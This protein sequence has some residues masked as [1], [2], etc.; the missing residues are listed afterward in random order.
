M[1]EVEIFIV[2]RTHTT[3]YQTEPN[4]RLSCVERLLSRFKLYTGYLETSQDDNIVVDFRIVVQG[5]QERQV[6]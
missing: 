4:I 2:G 5:K 1:L 3:K 6:E